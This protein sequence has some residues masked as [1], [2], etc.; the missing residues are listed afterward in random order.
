MEYEVTAIGDDVIDTDL[1][2]YLDELMEEDDY[3][4]ELIQMD[5][6]NEGDGYICQ[7]YSSEKGAFYEGTFES[8]GLFNPRKLKVVTTEYPN[9]DNVVTSVEY[10]KVH[11]ENV[12]GDTIGKG[13]SAHIWQD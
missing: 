12:D 7:F 4:S 9:G 13:Y 2:D 5:C 1:E 10:D 11:I 3:T 8:K 6:S